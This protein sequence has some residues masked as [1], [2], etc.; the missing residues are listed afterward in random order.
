MKRRG[1]GAARRTPEE[2]SMGLAELWAVMEQCVDR[3][4]LRPSQPESERQDP[5]TFLLTAA[6]AEVGTATA[7]AAAGLMAALNGTPRQVA[8]A[9]T[10]ALEHSLGMTCDPVLGL[11]QA[12][13]AV[14][15]VRSGASQTLLDLDGVLRALFVCD[16]KVVRFC[17]LFLRLLRK[18]FM[19]RNEVL[20]ENTIKELKESEM[21]RWSG[22]FQEFKGLVRAL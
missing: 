8:A 16:K 11:V 20:S 9:A 4:H 7:M 15:L 2:V 1:P 13:N 10:S 12:V 18:A 17:V 6:T 19:Q 14:A 21:K 5:A 22:R 3:G